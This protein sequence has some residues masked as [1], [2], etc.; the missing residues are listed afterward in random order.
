MCIKHSNDSILGQTPV[1]KSWGCLDH[2]RQVIGTR[3]T[4]TTDWRICQITNGVTLVSDAK[5]LL[6]VVQS[7]DSPTFG[8]L[9]FS[10][11]LQNTCTLKCLHLWPSKPFLVLSGQYEEAG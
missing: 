9:L 10:N 5:K 1:G 2:H 3:V 7:S 4:Q 6:S 11:A 8:S